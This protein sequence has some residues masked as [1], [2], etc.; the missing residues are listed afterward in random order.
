MQE[1][2]IDHHP[3]GLA[4]VQALARSPGG[5]RFADTVLA[6]LE[7]DRVVVGQHLQAGAPV[8]G[9][10][11]GLGGNIG[12]RLTPEE[13]L[14]WQRQIIAGRMIGMGDPLPD[15]V[16]RTALLLR[17]CAL[18]RGG[19]GV[20]P[21]AAS[22]LL[23]LLNSGITPVVPQWGSIGAGDL[24]LSAHLV[25]P[26]LGLG[27]V[28][29]RGQ[30]M[31]AGQALRAAGLDEAVLQAKD[32]LGL[33]NASPVTAALGVVAVREAV[34]VLLVGLA[35]A[36]LCMEGYAA[37][38][39]VL[40]RRI[41]AARP[42][43]EQVAV[44]GLLRALLQGSVLT[45]AP[46][47]AIQDAL[48]LRTPAQN[49]GAAYPLLRLLHDAVE[50]EVNGSGDSPLVLA[51]S[52]EML[53]T[54]NFHTPMMA[55]AADALA[56][57]LVQLSAASVQRIIK[58]QTPHFSGLPKYLS[59]VGGASVGF[60]AMQ[61][62]AAA[63]HA[64]VRLYAA[65]A[66]LDAFPVSD[67]AEDHAPQTLLALRKLGDA[68]RALRHLIAIEAL[69]AAQAVDLRQAGPLGAG[70]RLVLDALRAAVPALAEDRPPG[71]DAARVEAV[72]FADPLVAALGVLAV[73]GEDTGSLHPL[74]C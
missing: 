53:S 12:Y 46:P 59:P 6:R 23:A 68:L 70:T 26:I 5:F 52:G 62:T 10:N 29:Y 7:A 43:G 56:I 69:V 64:Q 9:L 40:D 27:Q 16:A 67:G 50:A 24:G 74:L 61:K 41:A 55:V 73:G 33:I 39:T 38:L 65:P 44:T 18:A 72:L 2:L 63:L 8:Y 54:A 28:R 20:S 51:D 1:H 13:T 15:E 17:V 31:A 66:A 37:N 35:V 3:L 57:A 58:L 32:G 45:Q 34:R 49:F 36:A 42:A 47:R 22:A 30:T 11:T 21:Q 4:R 19:T 14:A 60:N 48:S 71:P 25:A